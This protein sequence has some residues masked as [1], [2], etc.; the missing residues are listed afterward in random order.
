V[1][2]F[3]KDNQGKDILREEI[4]SQCEGSEETTEKTRK[5]WRFWTVPN[6]LSVLRLVLLGPTVWALVSNRNLIAFILFVA[7]SITD[8]LDGMIARRFNQESE[9]GKI[10]DP[11]ADKVTLNVL[12]M[13]MAFQGRIPMFLALIVLTRDA[14]ILGGSLVLLTS[15]TFVPQSNWAG[16]AAGVSFFALL[17]AGLLNVKWLLHDFLV[18]L[19]TVLLFITLVIYTH[20]FFMQLKKIAR[21]S[22]NE[23]S[24]NN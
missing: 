23:N 12:A 18:P 24:G 21:S 19:V 11:V 14:T 8:A 3:S 16:K 4:C 22:G 17:C 9:W 2:L 6:M 13:I 20:S 7:S 1:N 15:R 5:S 10:L